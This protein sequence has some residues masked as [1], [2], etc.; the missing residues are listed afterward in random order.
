LTALEAMQV[1][2][3]C[4]KIYE[5]RRID[6]HRESLYRYCVRSSVDLRE[7]IIPF[8]DTYSLITSKLQDYLVFKDVLKLVRQGDHLTIEGLT[9]VRKRAATMNRKKL[10]I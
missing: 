4:G 9:E 5:N 1:Y 7:K 3:G 8:F 2:F 6:N 10:R